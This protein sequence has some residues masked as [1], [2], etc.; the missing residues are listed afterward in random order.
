MAI[1]NFIN[2]TAQGR[3]KRSATVPEPDD[4][5]QARLSRVFGRRGYRGP[6]ITSSNNLF[7]CSHALVHSSD[8]RDEKKATATVFSL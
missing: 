5:P 1:Q 7:S 2:Q 8:L 6:A 3:E 4:R